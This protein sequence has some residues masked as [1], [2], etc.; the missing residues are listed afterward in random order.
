QAGQAGPQGPQ[1]P[2]GPQGAQGPKGDP[3]APATKLFAFVE[4]DG[5]LVADRSSGA[6]SVST[7]SDGFFTVEFNQDGS[8]CV[9][10]A[11]TEPIGSAV[12]IFRGYANV[13]RDGNQPN[14]TVSVLTTNSGGQTFGFDFHLAVFCK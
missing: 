12:G 1:G 10:H 11:T 7:S 9:F 6:T 14:N 5:V 8:K 13:F 4:R 2:A 3:G